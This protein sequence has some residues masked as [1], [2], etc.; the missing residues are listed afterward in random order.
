VVRRVALAAEVP[1]FSTHTTRH[2]C[3]TDLAR[4]G[5]ELHAIATFAG[6]RSTE[7]TLR[8]I[9]LSGRDLAAKLNRSMAHLHA[10]RVSMLTTLG[11]MT[12]GGDQS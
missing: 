5:W 4:M 9:H 8:Y 3:L 6:H 11:P 10:E 2:L 7:S 1:R 12:S